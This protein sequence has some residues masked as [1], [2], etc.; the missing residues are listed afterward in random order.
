M[1]GQDALALPEC[2]F[3]SAG[4]SASSVEV[5]EKSGDEESGKKSQDVLLCGLWVGFW[6][7]LIPGKSVAFKQAF[8]SISPDK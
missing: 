7:Q 3:T 5:I 2:L 4:V 8:F 1:A 6:V